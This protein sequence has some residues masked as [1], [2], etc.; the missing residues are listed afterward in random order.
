MMTAIDQDNTPVKSNVNIPF[1]CR[2]PLNF[3]RKFFT[4][5]WK[6]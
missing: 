3:W 4:I 6:S 5:I 2:R 1:N